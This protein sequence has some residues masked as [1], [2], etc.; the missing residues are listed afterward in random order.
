MT[1]AECISLNSIANI[2]FFDNI[3]FQSSTTSSAMR[4]TSGFYCENK[5]R[6]EPDIRSALLLSLE[7]AR[8][9]GNSLLPWLFSVS[10]YVEFMHCRERVERCWNHWG[11]PWL[12]L[13]ITGIRTRD[14]SNTKE[15]LL[16]L[17]NENCCNSLL[18]LENQW[19][20]KHYLRET[21]CWRTRSLS[22]GQICGGMQYGYH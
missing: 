1:I 14:L 9:Y 16:S 21:K 18:H 11:R 8:F 10:C 7:T 19:S 17:Q 6:Y 13:L 12:S 5:W 22:D 4:Q 15:S 20:T 2:V 3:I